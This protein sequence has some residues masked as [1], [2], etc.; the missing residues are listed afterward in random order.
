MK[1][2]NLSNLYIFL[3]LTFVFKNLIHHIT[4]LLCLSCIVYSLGGG[5]TSTY[6]LLQLWKEQQKSRKKYAG[7]VTPSV[8]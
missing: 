8:V 6:I 5:S 2:K 7:N 1:K 4:T 3:G